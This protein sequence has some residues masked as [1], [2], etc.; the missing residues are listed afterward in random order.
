MSDVTTG[1]GRH[2]PTPARLR[3]HHH[4]H[5]HLPHRPVCPHKDPQGLL[6]PPRPAAPA[7]HTGSGD[8]PGDRRLRHSRTVG[9][10]VGA[11]RRRARVVP[12]AAERSRRRTRRSRGLV[13]YRPPRG[14]RGGARRHRGRA[15]APHLHMHLFPRQASDAYVGL[16]NRCRAVFTPSP[17]TLDRVGG[18]GAGQP[19]G[20][21]D[22]LRPL[23]PSG[24]WPHP[25]LGAASWENLGEQSWGMEA[26][27]GHDRETGQHGI[28]DLA[29][30]L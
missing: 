7:G 9:T 8:P 18:S 12:E 27:S 5:S 4:H 15:T 2:T 26:I 1:V 11:R 16:P 10:G 25:S 13:R 29:D 3:T 14:A 20:S 24:G 28:D 30:L 22:G 21:A 17:A 19:R 6:I 23:T